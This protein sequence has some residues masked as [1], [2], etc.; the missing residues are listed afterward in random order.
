MKKKSPSKIIFG[1][2]ALSLLTNLTTFHSHA[3]DHY[4]STSGKIAENLYAVKAGMTNFYVVTNG[5]DYI[6]ID[7]GSNLK[8]AKQELHKLKIDPEKIQAL[9]LT[10]SD[11]DHIA[12]ISL[13]KN[14]RI[15]LSTDEEEMVLNKKRRILGFINNNLPF[16]YYLHND[17]WETNVGDI[18]VRAIATPGHT[19][20]SMSYLVNGQMLFTGDAL[21][22][23]NGKAALFT[24]RF[25]NMDEKTQEKSIKKL[26]SLRNITLLCTGHHGF[27]GNF[28]FAMRE[29]RNQ[30]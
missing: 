11:R 9:F 24:P 17:G 25:F 16:E 23:K 13:F 8:K 12:A 3:K 4:P 20:G 22:L 2:L 18:T 30:M 1:T 7:A 26:A 6:C 15:Y 10:H 19:F 5:I 14:A 21:S 27:T 28:E 29:W